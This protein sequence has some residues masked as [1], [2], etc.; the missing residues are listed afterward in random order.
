[1]L[2]CNVAVIATIVVDR[3]NAAV[4][5]KMREDERKGR[6]A[7]MPSCRVPRVIH[8]RPVALFISR[9]SYPSGQFL[10]IITIF[11]LATAAPYGKIIIK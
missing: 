9:S 4:S 7:V 1:L 3:V 8:Q 2:L 5:A 11:T 10:P 6:F